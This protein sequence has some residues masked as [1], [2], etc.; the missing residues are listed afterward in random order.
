MTKT[1]S[2]CGKKFEQ[3][4]KFCDDCGVELPKTK[5]E[6]LKIRE[7][8]AKKEKSEKE[9]FKRNAKI[10]LIIIGVVLVV[11]AIVFIPTKTQAYT[12]Q[13]PYASTEK[14]QTQEPYTVQVPYQAEE[15]YQETE[16]YYE[17]V[18]VQK[19]VPYTTKEYYDKEVD[20]CDGAVECT[21][22][23]ASFWYPDKC[24]KCSCYKLITNYRTETTYQN[25]AKTR[26]I[27]KYRTVTKY[28]TETRYQTV[29][30]SR[31]VTLYKD[32]TRYRKVNWIFN[33]CFYSCG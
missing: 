26:P 11:S 14:Y 33:E 29:T 18:P 13:V 7:E 3:K 6:E 24:I 28:T 19:Q 31:D 30:K 25:V 5:K 8:R 12:I 10:A 15:A 9:F 17:S 16:T 23:Q 22:T 32:E 21:C 4:D 1:C 20:Y 2:H 27:T